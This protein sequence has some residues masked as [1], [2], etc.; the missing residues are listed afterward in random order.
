MIEEIY[1]FSNNLPPLEIAS[2]LWQGKFRKIF[3]FHFMSHQS[4]VG[5]LHSS[6]ADE[7]LKIVEHICW[8]ARPIYQL[9]YHQKNDRS[10]AMGTCAGF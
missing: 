9:V 10:N 7:M 2:I 3:L 5:F 8:F 4:I 6:K 1:Q